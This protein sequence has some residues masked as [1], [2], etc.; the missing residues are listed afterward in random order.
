[1][2]LNLSELNGERRAVL[3]KPLAAKSQHPKDYVCSN[4]LLAAAETAI[5]LGQPLLLTGESGCGKSS[6]ATHL[7][8]RLGQGMESGSVRQLRAYCRSNMEFSDLFYRYDEV[9]RFQEGRD[10]SRSEFLSLEAFGEALLRASDPVGHKELRSAFLQ[11]DTMEVRREVVLIDEIDKAPRDVPND[12]LALWSS[13]AFRLPIPE[14]SRGLKSYEI[15]VPIENMPIVVVTSNSEKTLPEPFL[16]RCVYFDIPFPEEQL[17]S[18]VDA[19]VYGASAKSQLV[20]EALILLLSLRERNPQKKPSI[21][22]LISF[23]EVRLSRLGT[24]EIGLGEDWQTDAA[25]TLLKLRSDRDRASE[26][27]AQIDWSNQLER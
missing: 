8:W 22:E 15:Q 20:T 23:V 5:I 7:A 19:R 26:L 21:A 2:S 10:R 24:T 9:G 14:L 6:F 3:P 27:F 17:A 13:D 4:D 25:S 1:M 12:L 16:R 11:N 18:I